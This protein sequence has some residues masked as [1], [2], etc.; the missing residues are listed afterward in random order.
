VVEL[1]LDT[2]DQWDST[3]LTKSAKGSLSPA[4]ASML[5]DKGA[6]INSTNCFRRTP[7]GWAAAMGAED[8]VK[9]LLDRGADPNIAAQ[10]GRTCLLSAVRTKSEEFTSML[11]DAVQT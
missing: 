1:L 11:A 9:L 8:M 2:R 4:I 5:L 3:P 10:D 6:D 7:L